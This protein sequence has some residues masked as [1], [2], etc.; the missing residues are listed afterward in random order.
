M[1]HF[2]DA[3][4]ESQAYRLIRELDVEFFY[5]T[6]H[7][8]QPHW[9]GAT[10]EEYLALGEQIGWMELTR[11]LL[12]KQQMQDLYWDD[13]RG[14]REAATYLWTQRDENLPEW[15]WGYHGVYA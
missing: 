5:G 9:K 10:E 14:D 7:T 3:Y 2:G 12:I 1:A 15:F 6:D 8:S 11:Q 4:W 13:E